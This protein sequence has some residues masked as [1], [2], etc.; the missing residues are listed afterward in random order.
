MTCAQLRLFD[1]PR[2][3]VGR[4]GGAQCF[5]NQPFAVWSYLCNRAYAIAP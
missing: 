1:R 3:V 5:D 4:I 2:G